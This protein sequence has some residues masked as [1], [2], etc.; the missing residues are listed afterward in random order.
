MDDTFNEIKTIEDLDQAL[1][2]SSDHPVLLFKHSNSCSISFRALSQLESYLEDHKPE[3]EHHL[4]TVQTARPVSN[5]IEARLRVEHH[6]PQAILVRN[7]RAI[8]DASHFSITASAL[9]EAVRANT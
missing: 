6:T 7:G 9:K 2:A 8:W 4:V 3:V 1:A 5:E